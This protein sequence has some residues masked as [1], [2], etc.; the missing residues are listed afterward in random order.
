MSDK[1]EHI[2]KRDVAW[3]YIATV[4]SVG[5]SVILWPFILHKMS[6]ETVGIWNVFTTVMMLTALLDFGF[7]PSFARNVSYIFSG[8]RT[9][10][11]QGVASVTESREVD[12]SLLSGTL[13]AMRRFY[14]WM[15]LLVFIVLGT[16]GTGYVWW[17][18]Q[19][20]SG[21][22]TDAMVAWL[23]LIALNC[24]NL[25]TYYYD[26]LL[27]GKGYVRRNQQINIT[28][29]ALYLGVAI[30][31]IYSGLGL[32]AIVSAQVISIIV[33]RALSYRVFF[34]REMRERIASVVPQ[35]SKAILRTISPNAIKI[36]LTGLGSFL[37]NQSAT[38]FGA[39]FLSL[40]QMGCYGLTL[41]VVEILGNCGG[42]FY[43]SYAPRLAQC[44]AEHD[45]QSL[46]RYY[47]YSV[48][49]LV[50]IYIV[51]GS[52]LVFLGDWA[53]GIIRSETLFLPTAMLCTM[54]VISFLEKNHGLAAGFIMA[55]NKIPF[56]I[57][58]LLSGGATVL[59]LWVFLS[60][61]DMGLWGLILAP[62]CAQI[63]Y[64]NWKWPSV[65]IRELRGANKK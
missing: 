17:I 60:P 61:L 12:Y 7:R 28:G 39:A 31:L 44:R 41:R 59:L 18:L 29:Q 3:G 64:Q 27:I 5:A 30:G 38:L 8:V 47:L 2:G 54:L 11:K 13:I 63:V 24:Y 23:L 10:Q 25:Y 46:W 45:L 22:R 6:A 37:V 58:S 49:S 15:S 50:L 9:L 21:D 35:D 14:R 16:A 20:Y 32:T 52:F 34:T 40:E 48:A 36:G 19:K 56:F 42:V 1:I 55:D 4:F 43:Q 65:V 53:L 33:R 57:P 62:G 51:G 26:A